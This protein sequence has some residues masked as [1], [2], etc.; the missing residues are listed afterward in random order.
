ME[1]AAVVVKF[2][3]RGYINSFHLIIYYSQNR[4]Y[5]TTTSTNGYIGNVYI[6]KKG[7]CAYV[8][9]I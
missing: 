5:N 6:N 7:H 8:P 3:L 2:I 1:L 4:L 9:N